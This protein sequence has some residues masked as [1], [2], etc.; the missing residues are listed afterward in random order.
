MT[1]TP[2]DVTTII[3]GVVIIEAA[4]LGL[5]VFGFQLGRSKSNK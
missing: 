2:D 3:I 4:I 5:I 1:C